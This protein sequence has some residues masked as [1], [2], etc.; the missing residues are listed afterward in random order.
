MDLLLGFLSP[1]IYFGEG[2]GL[3]K[4]KK[5]KKAQVKEA[6]GQGVGGGAY[7]TEQDPLGPSWDRRLPHTLC[8]TS[9]LKDSD[10]N[11]S[12]IAAEFFRC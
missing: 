1:F 9:S 8:C 5:K 11:I 4:K 12:C 3:G 6:F 7:V 2:L 10:N